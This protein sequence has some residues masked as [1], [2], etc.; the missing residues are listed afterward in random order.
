MN[1]N[2]VLLN[3]NIF[4]GILI[5]IVLVVCIRYIVVLFLEVRKAAQHFQTL[6][7]SIETIQADFLSMETK[8]TEIEET[9]LITPSPQAKRYG[10]VA[11]N[12]IK[13]KRKT[14]IKK[15]KKQEKNLKKRLKHLKTEERL[16][17]TRKARRKVSKTYGK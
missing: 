17:N 13:Q 3:I 6:Q 8:L 16:K 10:K 5:G 9:P 12:I 11:A 4:I 15:M 2:N 7:P 1:I 14:R